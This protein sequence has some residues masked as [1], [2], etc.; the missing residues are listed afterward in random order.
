LSLYKLYLLRHR[1]EKERESES[2][3]EADEEGSYI[4]IDKL[5]DLGISAAGTSTI[6]K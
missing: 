4:E 5:Q 6:R 1:K 3:E 2:A